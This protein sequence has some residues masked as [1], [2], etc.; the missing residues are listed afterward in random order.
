MS[1]RRAGTVSA[2]SRRPAARMRWCTAVTVLAV[3]S[4]VLAAPVPALARS[5]VA[6]EKHGGRPHAQKV[7]KP[8]DVKVLP[9]VHPVK[10]PPRHGTDA[11]PHV[12]SPPPVKPSWPRAATFTVA[13]GGAT[14]PKASTTGGAD[15][16]AAVAVAPSGTLAAPAGGAE[17]APTGH[18]PASV[19]VTVADHRTAAAAGVR[20]TVVQV[21]RA[22]GSTEAGAVDVSLA[23]GA[24]AEAFG[25]DFADRLRLVHLPPCAL[26]TPDV[27]SCRVQT[28]VRT[29][30]DRER[31]RLLATVAL[32]GAATEPQSRWAAAPQARTQALVLAATSTASGADGAYTATSLKSSDSWTISGNSASFEWS[33]PMNSPPS[34]GS[35]GT[36]L[37]L[38]YDSG[39]VDGRTTVSNGQTSVVGEGF[40][41]GGASSYIET[42]Y[43]PCAKVDPTGWASS[44]DMCLGVANA[45]I[46][47]GAH[48]GELVRDDAD[49]SK[50]RL[51]ADDGTRVQFLHGTTGGSNNTAN[52]AFWKVTG[53][54][55]TVYLYGANR[56][57][58]ASGG[59]GGDSPTYSTWSEP[60]FGTGS[61]TS[62][63]DPTG[64][65]SPQS[66]LQAWRW[67]LDYVIDPHGNVT[68]YSYARELDNYQHQSATTAYTRSGY[69]REID[70]G[71]Q[72][73]DVA[74]AT[75]LLADGNAAGARPAAT[76][77]FDY[78]PRC[79]NSPTNTACPTA[80]PSVGSGIA[81]TGITAGNQASFTDVPYDQHCDAGSTSCTVYSPAYF[82]TVRLTGVRTAVNAGASTGS[83]PS[84][85]PVDF[86][87]VDSYALNQSFPAPADHATAGN[88]PQLRLDSVSRTAYLTNA[89]GTVATSAAPAIPVVNFGY[90]QLPNRSQASSLYN[91]APFYRFRLDDITDELGAETLVAYGRPSTLDCG[92]TAPPATTANATLCFPEYFD[93]NGTLV[94]DWFNKYLVTGVT[95]NDNTTKNAGYRYAASRSTNFGYLGT[96]AWHTDDS[97]QAD[98]AHRT[99]DGFRGFRQV[100]ITSSGESPGANA[101]SVTTYFQG[102]DQDPT[103]YVCLN[104]SH[105][106]APTSTACPSGGY[107]DDNA[108]AGEALETQIYAS[109]TSPTVSQDVITVPQDPTGPGMVTAVHTRLSGLPPQRAHFSQVQRKITY[110]PLASGALRR[111]ETDYTYDDSLPSFAGSGG[112]GGNGHL[113]LADDKGDTDGNGNPNGDVQELCTFTGYAGNTASGVD[114]VQWT[115]Y[116]MT[117]ITSTVPAGRS[118][119]TTSETTATTVSQTQTLYDDQPPGTVAV[120]DATTTQAAASFNGDW[121]TTGQATYDRYGRKTSS[122]DADNHTT[123]LA[124]TPTTGLLPTQLATTDPAGWTSTITMDRGRG[125][126]ES[127]V[128]VN[129]RRS[130]AVYDG[131]G[132]VVKVWHPD[133]PKAQY[134]GTPNTVYDYGQ[135]GT[136]VGATAAAPNAFVETRTLRENNSYGLSFSILDGFGDQVQTQAT[137]PDGSAG[138]VS[139][140][141]EYNS[142]GKVTRT[143]TNNFDGGDTPG[144]TF[145][146]YG[147]ALASQTVTTYDGLSRPLT[148]TQYHNGVAVPGAT[149]TTAYPGVDR[150]DA[151]APAGNGTAS[152][153]AT[154]TFTDVRG[155][156]TALWSYHNSPPTPTGSAADADVTGYGF[157][158]VPGGTSSTTTDATTRNIWTT[159]TTDLLGHHI[160]KSDPDAGTSHTV[161]DDA[162][163]QVQTQD[164]RGQFVSSY[165]DALGRKTAEYQAQRPDSGTPAASTELASWS[166]DTA[167]SSDG[168]PNRGLPTGSTRYTDAGTTAYTSGVTGYDAGGRP[169]GSSVTIPAADGNG[170][171][172]GTYRTSN[173]YTPV[174]GLLDHTDLPAAG[175]VPAETV[176]NSYNVNGLLLAAGGNADYVVATQYDQLGRILSRTLGDYPYQMVQQNLYDSATGRV[177]N[178]FTDTTAGRSTVNP[179]QLNTYSV[180]DVSY[181]YDAAGRLTST[182]DLQNWTASGSYQP[183]PQARDLQCYTYDAAGRLTNAWADKGD[184]IPSATTDLNSPTTATGGLGSCASSTSNKPPS[185]AS[186]LGGPAPYWQTYAFD[187]NGS[188]TGDRS[189]VTDHDITGNTAKDT[190]RTSNY[191]APGSTGPNLLSSVTTTGGATATDSYTY[192]AAGDTET[193]T[194][195]SGPRQRLTWDAEGHLTTVTDSSTSPATTA[196][197]LYDADGNQLIRRDAKGSTGTTTLYLGSTELYLDSATGTVTGNRYYT[198]P[199]AP[200]IVAASSG[201]LTYEIADNQGTGST[202]VDA[203]TGHVVARRY[204]KPFGDPR[205]TA[206]PSWPDDHTF[207]DKTADASTGL[208]DIGA[209]K[210]DPVTGRFTSADP[211]F[212]PGSPQAIG[213]Y[214]YAGDDPVSTSDPTGLSPTWAQIIAAV[215]AVIVAVVAV[216]AAGT[217]SH[218]GTT[219]SASGSHQ[220]KQPTCNQGFHYNGHGCGPDGGVVTPGIA[221][222][223]DPTGTR[224]LFPSSDNL[225]DPNRCVAVSEQ[226]QHCIYTEYTEPAN[227]LESEG[228]GI[229]DG[230]SDGMC[231]LNEIP[232][233]HPNN[234]GGGGPGVTRSANGDVPDWY[235]RLMHDIQWVPVIGD[236]GAAAMLPWDAVHG[237]TNAA[238][239]DALGLIPFAKEVKGLEGVEK[240]TVKAADWLGHDLLS[241]SPPGVGSATLPPSPSPGPPP[242]G[243]S[244]SVTPPQAVAPPMSV[245]PPQPTP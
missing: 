213:G 26:T 131:L 74:T 76:V 45:A 212:Q 138:L 65:E 123:K 170:A 21:A 234:V 178:T 158:Y 231:Q 130:D 145:R 51:A 243:P 37:S 116:P 77:L 28:P 190:V 192:D 227:W 61:G 96:P 71:W 150:T 244:T 70:Y 172:A 99:A 57:P 219:L 35:G 16:D 163:L 242:P 73:A 188:L 137:P 84:G 4:G 22:D 110:A 205:G 18:G 230:I 148:V 97:E 114:G 10:G 216:V 225:Y 48:A 193:R 47:G 229:C 217:H 164:A 189:S 115:A 177:T 101:K 223:I 125:V 120:G 235:P 195:A 82:S 126:T 141:A 118:C 179:T 165:Y 175:G 9:S 78:A 153:A 24:W 128:D 52:Q 154:S 93:N 56:L 106:Q 104:D 49:T 237:D 33:Y 53:T 105:H 8:R 147:N 136:T 98:P 210:Y 29:V 122:T 133:H 211:V 107:R 30:N 220:P 119:T 54:D 185:S 168:H 198:Y 146:Y 25:G 3:L 75:G 203:A 89:D 238:F 39:S 197:Y 72:T 108:L 215:V 207:L 222:G 44:G 27:P 59:T 36:S 171:L 191:P 41:L 200:S 5:A 173:S 159:T 68:R 112:V 34:L 87:A 182:A 19:R 183:G 236:L 245:T 152:A 142:Q 208:V 67:N 135:F 79:V 80:P 174:T 1:F 117:T 194:L 204:A 85:T 199:S 103:G 6:A 156:K 92:T 13:L 32:P 166:Y 12:I 143:A 129:G 187:A 14:V 232:N 202:A 209:R 181:T 69:L 46:S 224:P 221:R 228:N 218:Q 42:S 40:E 94:L 144:G 20:G 121:T 233:P 111:S 100:Q 201:S 11:A 102:M 63:N 139:T 7:W 50:W 43:K 180:D 162:G 81:T 127:V 113:I 167:S 134:A 31:R 95:V 109:D 64:T 15:A 83:Q 169:L 196:N 157:S 58:S 214:A 23:Y 186:S 239:G 66:C 140:Q 176:Y 62:C 161:L 155:R 17:R 241:V 90:T 55:G 160:T 60:V 124:L 38:A 88:R 2:S 226:D 206:A 240:W 86:K 149:T 132:R 91:S 184:Q 151:T